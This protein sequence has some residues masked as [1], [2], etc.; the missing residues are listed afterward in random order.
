MVSLPLCQTRVEGRRLQ[1]GLH[2]VNRRFYP[3]VVVKELYVT[4]DF[5]SQIMY[6]ILNMLMFALFIAMID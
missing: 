3:I 2:Q 1:R 4:Y 6:Y 5:S